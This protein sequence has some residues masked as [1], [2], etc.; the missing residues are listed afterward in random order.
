MFRK[1]KKRKSRRFY[2]KKKREESSKLLE[3]SIVFLALLILIYGFSFIKKLSQNE[4]TLE[5]SQ[6][7][8]L[9]FVRTQILNGCQKEGLAK[10]LADRLRGLRVGNIVYDVIQTGNSE[11]SKT[12]QSFILDRTVKEGANP[13]EIALLTAQALGIDPESVLGKG[14][15]DNYE[16][17]ALTI[18][19]GNDYHRLF[20]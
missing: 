8:D 20:E 16:E 6:D 9:L 4:K 12:D 2:R 7:K 10:K 19:I 11:Y 17:I 13:S 14:L 18:V 5:A 1:N 15:K 3:I